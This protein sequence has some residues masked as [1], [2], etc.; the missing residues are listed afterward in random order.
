ML[1]PNP[2][3]LA[4]EHAAA[5]AEEA[6]HVFQYLARV[7]RAAAELAASDAEEAAYL[8][9]LADDPDTAKESAKRAS[10]LAEWAAKYAD[11]ADNA[12]TYLDSQGGT[13]ATAAEDIE[14]EA[15]VEVAAAIARAMSA[16]LVGV[17]EHGS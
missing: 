17:V 12:L 7:A 6:G 11:R 4:T 13:L 14:P 16:A 3:D 9:P 2:A 1:P 5:L 10:D 8:A 15:M